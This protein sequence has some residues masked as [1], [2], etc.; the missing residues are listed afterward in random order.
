M[1]KQVIEI[2]GRSCTL[3]VDSNADQIILQPVDSHDLEAIDSE[4]QTVCQYTSRPFS[5]VAFKISDWQKE[6]TAWASPAVF[7]KVPFGDG[8]ADTLRYVTDHLMP[9]LRAMN[10]SSAENPLFLLGGYSLAG[11]FA[12]WAGTV[13]DVFSGIAAVSPSVWYPKWTD[14][15][16]KNTML[17]GAVYLSLGDKEERVKNQIMAQVGNALRRQH[18]LLLKQGCKTVL[19]WNSGNH[20]TDAD[21]RTG[22]GFA[23]LLNNI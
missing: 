4:V 17:S 21:K 22:R 15:A 7:G 8:A 14:Y 5:L 6:L 23:W 2:E 16:E 18:D 19:E 20:F 11:L 9:A 1:E 13:T 10:I 12:L 3:Y